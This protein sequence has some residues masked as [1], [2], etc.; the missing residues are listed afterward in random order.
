[1][2]SQGPPHPPPPAVAGTGGA[3]R[4]QAQYYTFRAKENCN[5]N[6]IVVRVNLASAL[7]SVRF[8]RTVGGF[9]RERDGRRVAARSRIQTAHVIW[10]KPVVGM[11]T[12][13]VVNCHMHRM[14]AKRKKGFVAGYTT[15]FDTL[16][17]DIRYGTAR[18]YQGEAADAERSY[19]AS[20]DKWRTDKAPVPRSRCPLRSRVPSGRGSPVPRSRCPL[21]LAITTAVAVSPPVAGPQCYGA[22]P[23]WR[24]LRLTTSAALALARSPGH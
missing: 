21:R 2:C 11:T 18:S 20:K 19:Q 10:R 9:C 5:T 8:Q 16:A 15:F 7:A 6:F 3:D 24:L 17:E 12:T 23:P 13:V 14:S 1:M 22:T 4:P